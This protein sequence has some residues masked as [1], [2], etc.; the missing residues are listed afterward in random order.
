MKG[1]L[2]VL[3][4]LTMIFAFSACKNTN[5]DDDTAADTTAASAVTEGD[6]TPDNSEVKEQADD[7]KTTAKQ[8]Y[9]EATAPAENYIKIEDNK[10]EAPAYEMEIPDGFEVKSDDEGLLLENRKGT[11]QFN[12][13]DKTDVVTDFD[14]YASK[15]YSTLQAI[16]AVSGELEDIVINGISMK[17]FAMTVAEDGEQLEAYVYL[18]KLQGRTLMIT[19]TSKDGGLADAN[20]ANEF[21][22]KID[23]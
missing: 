13:M 17:R 6:E 21:V 8:Q 11:I 14:D 1:F 5:A 23:F 12:I 9:G 10:V 16:G 4:I 15:T 7:E 20:A 2:S 18:A 3:L 22:A 19:L